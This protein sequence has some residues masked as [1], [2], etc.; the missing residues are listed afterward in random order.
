MAPVIAPLLAAVAGAAILRAQ[1]P[2][3]D[4]KPG[5]WEMTSAMQT[6]GRSANAAGAPSAWPP[7]KACLTQ[8]KL[9]DYATALGGRNDPTCKRT[10]SSSTSRLQV[11]HIEC[12]GGESK[13]TSDIR[14][15]A[16]S[17]EQ[18][19][20]RGKMNVGEGPVVTMDTTGRW[21]SSSCGTVK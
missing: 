17:P 10:F 6:S 1:A 21:L 19:H 20:V 4:V 13:V 11:V 3:L 16:P 5:L 15:E 18:L 12:T 14:I 7:M 8:Q 9:D 2:P